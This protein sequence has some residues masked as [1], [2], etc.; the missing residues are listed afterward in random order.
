[1]ILDIK[2]ISANKKSNN[3]KHLKIA[4]NTDDSDYFY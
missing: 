4:E 2:E 3:N 1:M